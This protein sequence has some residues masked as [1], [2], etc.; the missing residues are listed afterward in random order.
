[1]DDIKSSTQY[2]VRNP[3]GEQDPVTLRGLSQR[4]EGLAGKTIGLFATEAKLAARPILEAVERKLRD[5]DASLKFSWFVFNYNKHIAE[6]DEFE[7]FKKWTKEVDAAV[8][9]VG[10]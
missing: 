9:A 6:T 2:E 3:W 10:D 8:V 1:M 5:R 7:N 4:I